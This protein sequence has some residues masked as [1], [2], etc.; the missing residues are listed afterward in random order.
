MKLIDRRAF[1]ELGLASGAGLAA[2]TLLPHAA[3]AARRPNIPSAAPAGKRKLVV[4]DMGGG[5]DGLSMFPPKGSGATADAYRSLRTRT[6][7]EFEDMI[8]F[9]G[10]D[11][12][13]MHKNLTRI[14]AWKPAVLLGVGVNKPDL[15][16]FEMQRRW[17]SGDQDSTHL[18]A[19]GFLGRLCDQIGERTAPAVGIS[20]GYGPSPSLNAA[21]VAT[22][23]MNP[24]SDGEFP[25]FWDV[26][27]D[28]AWKAAWKIMAERQ[29]NE[30]VPFCSARD[31][32]AYARRFSDLAKALPGQGDG[33]PNSELG[34][35]LRLAGQML[36]QDNGIRIIH[37]PVFA[38][39]DTH[40][41]HRNRHAE[42]M[43]MLDRAVD[44]FLKEMVATNHADEVLVVTISEFG[45]RV[46]DNESN[47][48]DHGAG[49]F[50]MMLGP[51]NQGFYGDYPDLTSLD[52][53]DNIVATV[54]M[55]D[56]YATIAQKWFGV[57][58]SEVI[59][60]G[61]AMSGIL[62]T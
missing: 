11:S 45:R 36:R 27:M 14:K 49:S 59:S 50:V 53:D 47:G 5:N 22:L 60:G 10:S 6:R 4:L 38:D 3:A 8:D 31:G 39:F 13:G 25:R 54:H 9:G 18:T 28:S 19:T 56:Y 61:S 51:V 7:I 17:W 35:Q 2:T 48:L 24:Y 20:L 15:S 32:A 29:S 12:V 43:G 26:D 30:T 21:R 62:D 46:P 44:A 37:I 34:V 41:D 58:S 16:H 55:N 23:S 33:Y 1:L 57:P 52:R 40:D 42:I